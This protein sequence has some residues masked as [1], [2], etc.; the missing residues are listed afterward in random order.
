MKHFVALLAIG[1]NLGAHL[2]AQKEVV[3]THHAKGT[4]DVK[5]IPQPADD[6]AEHAGKTQKQ[7]KKR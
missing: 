6:A 2:H 3:V 5:V 4:F 1:L 7:G